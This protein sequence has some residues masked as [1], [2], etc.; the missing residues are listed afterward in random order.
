VKRCHVEEEK[1]D[2]GY[3]PVVLNES[4]LKTGEEAYD[5]YNVLTGILQTEAYKKVDPTA[6][7]VNNLYSFSLTG[8]FKEAW[9]EYLEKGG[10]PLKTQCWYNHARARCK[11][12]AKVDYLRFTPWQD[13]IGFTP[14][15]NTIGLYGDVYGDVWFCTEDGTVYMLYCQVCLYESGSLRILR[16]PLK[17]LLLGFQADWTA[18]R[19]RMRLRPREKGSFGVE[20]LY[21]KQDKNKRHA[22]MKVGA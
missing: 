2:E 15:Q 5:P 1:E 4:L 7:L 22:S 17:T 16:N 14:W 11:R 13:T 6:I 21:L 9:E 19:F 20:F 10:R 18:S 8:K 3:S 12:A